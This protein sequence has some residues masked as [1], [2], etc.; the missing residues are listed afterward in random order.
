MGYAFTYPV[1]HFLLNIPIASYTHYPTISTDMLSRVDSSRTWKLLY[2][3]AFALLYSWC[4]RY[5]DLVMTNSTWTM[6]HIESL[7]K[8]EKDKISIVYP[9]CDTKAL[10]K[11]SIDHAREKVIVCVAQFRKEK[12]H[13]TILQ[14]F[15]HLV[16]HVQPSLAGETRLLLIG[17]VRNIADRERVVM[18]KQMAKE[19]R[20]DQSV[21]FRLDE[22]WPKVVQALG[23]SWI[24][25]N[26]MWN[27]HFGIGVVEYM[28]AGLIPVVHDSAG[29]KLDI[30]TP[31]NDLPTGFHATDVSSF[32][33]AFDAAFSVSENACLAM[34]RRA[35]QSCD[36]FSES[37]FERSWS[38]ATTSL[39]RLE[40]RNRI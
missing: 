27:E 5:A 3:K 26:A 15:S 23:S 36:R 17:T 13:E 20:I 7:W 4:G 8:L 30:V 2:W 33:A 24:G 19:L 12:D 39:V 1:V 35:R 40:K 29:P 32:A 37:T 31:Y 14:S 38:T 11:L 34:R 9:P 25:V 21:E 18:L 6:Q 28:A 10:S 16:H 22:P